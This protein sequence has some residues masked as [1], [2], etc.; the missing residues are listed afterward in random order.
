MTRLHPPRE[1]RLDL[2][3]GEIELGFLHHCLHPG[4]FRAGDFDFRGRRVPLGEGRVDLLQ[5]ADAV[6]CQPLNAVVIPHG[7]FVLGLAAAKLRFGQLL[8]RL[9]LL[10]ALDVFGVVDVHERVADVDVVAEI[11]VDGG[12]D[13][14]DARCNGDRLVGGYRAGIG[15]QLAQGLA[16]CHGDFDSRGHA[17]RP[18]S[19]PA[20][21]TVC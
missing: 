1:R 16:L 5:H 12:D 11:D 8:I 9:G 10:S 20:R 6:L 3:V 4:Q 13:A 2:R 7:Q 21:S 15:D 17:R 14:G 18:G 19:R